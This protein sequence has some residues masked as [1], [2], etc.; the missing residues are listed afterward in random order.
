M[1]SA[2]LLEKSEWKLAVS[3]FNPPANGRRCVE[4]LADQLLFLS[5][6]FCSLF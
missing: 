6:A 4:E 1:E 2:A 5:F 3:V